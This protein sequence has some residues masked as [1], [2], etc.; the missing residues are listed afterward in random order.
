MRCPGFCVAIAV[1]SAAPF[2]A[3]AAINPP[4]P[5]PVLFVAQVPVPGDDIARETVASTFANHLPLT[6][7]APR[8]GDLMLL[9][10]TGALR[11]LTLEA[12][13]GSTGAGGFQD[14]NAIAVRDPA[15]HWSGMK[16]I[17]S[18][19]VGAPAQAGDAENYT[20]QL[21][22][23]TG[24]GSAQT[25]SITKVPNQPPFNNIYPNYL[26]DGSVVF[27]SDRPRNGAA[28]LYPIN[29]E[30]RGQPANS[31]LWRLDPTN[32]ALSLLEHTP[33]GAFSPFVD[34]F[35]RIAFVRWDHLMQDN[36]HT[37]AS[38]P[39][40]VFDY[41]SEAANAATQTAIELY[42]EPINAVL[43]SNLNGFEI[44]QFFPWTINQ[45]GTRE[46]ILN[47]IGRHEL[48]QFFGRSYTN[49]VSLVNFDVT[50]VTRTNPNSI[51]NFFQIREDPVVAGRYLG[52]DAM[53]FSTHAS[54]QVIALNAAQ[55]GNLLNAHDMT[56][57]YITNRATS[58]VLSNVNNIGHFRDPLP[59]SDGTPATEGTLLAAFSPTP[60][61]EPSPAPTQPTYQFRLN[62]LSKNRLA[63]NDAV[64]GS[65]LTPGIVKNVSYY[66]GTNLIS[67]SG[68]LWE[69]QPVEV[70]ARSAPTALLEP[71]IALPEQ[72]AFASAGVLESDLRAF[73]Q[74]QNLALLVVRNVT[75]RDAADK[76]QPFNLHVA[77]GTQTLGDNGQIYDL[78]EMQFF[79]A[80]QVRGFGTPANPLPGRRTMTRYLNDAQALRFN[81][82]GAVNPGAQTIAA[83]GSV[84]LFV[85][86]RR[87]MAWQTL[88]PSDT[89]TPL[90]ANSPVVRERYWIEYQPGEIRACDGCHGVNT[91]NQAGLLPATNT[92]Q[93]LI[94][95][96]TFWKQHDDLI[97]KD[98]F[99]P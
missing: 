38:P 8:G 21:Y 49:D 32:G 81:P 22:E 7:A 90:A 34:S 70:R 92:P 51:F 69:L 57:Q 82:G 65:V 77:G 23:V 67:Y 61:A 40:P 52:V 3:V 6:A 42:P 33:S 16:A 29:D 25:A 19:V 66:V 62:R 73:L 93:A 24:L 56:V 55:N 31:G 79:E 17:F 44:N 41:V 46:E 1:C 86:A 27:V 36:N 89:S 26:S 95:L 50:L 71:A 9:S 10:S 64:N 47:H 76:Q 74:T 30:Y 48:K 39:F 12:G 28:Q 54:G 18:M 14:A 85:P 20:W 97:F 13:Y 88:S 43:G 45:D 4:L 99:G 53:E 83:D 98:A 78:A 75:S 15:M 60:G 11:N 91:T 96:L 94:D 37:T 84:A 80:D 2:A 87:A 59:M 5:N 68:N 58:S 63:N 72:Q 35:G